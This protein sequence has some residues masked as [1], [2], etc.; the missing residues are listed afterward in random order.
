MWL[1][2]C[3]V[4]FTKAMVNGTST[5]S[6]LEVMFMMKS[7]YPS[8]MVMVSC[9]VRAHLSPSVN[10]GHSMLYFLLRAPAFQTSASKVSSNGC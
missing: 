8:A 10:D 2:L 7:W 4:S 3:G 6:V 5:Y 1:C 9:R